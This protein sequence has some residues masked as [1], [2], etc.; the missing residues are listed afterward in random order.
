MILIARFS[1]VFLLLSFEL[2]L[3]EHDAADF[4][5]DVSEESV[6]LDSL[7]LIY[8]TESSSNSNSLIASAAYLSFVLFKLAI[9]LMVFFVTKI[10][11][12]F[13]F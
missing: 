7:L 12:S 13:G 11:I 3:Y 9:G 10:L 8:E 1:S 4:I 5:Y 2:S 6:N